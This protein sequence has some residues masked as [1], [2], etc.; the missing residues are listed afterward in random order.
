MGFRGE[1]LASISAVSEFSLETKKQ[2]ESAGTKISFQNGQKKIEPC[3]C[4]DG[5]II[6]I[7]NLFYN[8]P[9]RKKFLKTINTEYNHILEL[10]TNIVLIHPQ[11]SF[12]LTH[13]KKLIYNLAA[14]DIWLDRIK[15][16]LGSDIS[17]QLI[18]I[19]QK[20]TIQI[21]GYISK[22]QIARQ[23]RKSQY[24]FV[25]HRPIQDYII[26]K[27]I[28]EA[29]GT[30]IPKELHPVFIINIVINPGLIDVNVHPRKAE[31]KFENINQVYQQIFKLVQ[32]NLVD[33]KITQDINF[34]PS[35][36]R[37]FQLKTSSTTNNYKPHF[38]YQPNLKNLKPQANQISKAIEFSKQI[39]ESPGSEEI[40]PAQV[41]N[42]RLLGQIHNS[43]LLVEA[44]EGILIIDQHAAAERILYQQFKKYSCQEK[45][46][47]Q[48][49]LLPLTL[50][51]SAKEVEIINQS[52]EFLKQ[53]GFDIEVFG[54]NSFI[55]NAIPQEL[56]KLD[57]KQ[58]ILGLI[59]D[60]EEHDLRLAKSIEEK[61]DLIL[62]YTACR[63]AIKF[64]DKIEIEEQKKLLEDILNIIDKINT[65]PHGRP[66][67]ME[68][69][70]DQLAKNFK[71]K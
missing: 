39:L 11:I 24:I 66:F 52:Q 53:I 16:V 63:A 64:Q 36:I 33:K 45:V 56:N 57:L 68:L 38:S 31:I 25:N 54:N 2:T 44:P 15:Q 23:N 42:W 32:K 60:L 59:N 37:K 12:K 26:A 47:S 3:G 7:K 55:I 28:K 18:N 27:A 65:C 71:R 50:E 41:G 4:P 43:Y 21:Y 6:T 51:L 10:I 22:P 8:V 13:N 70:L 61:K 40:K 29:Y 69:S 46:K 9:A 67:L 19:D 35:K 48:N 30:L 1:A 34:D 17:N 58:T 62:K 5:T 20:G 14:T 49:L